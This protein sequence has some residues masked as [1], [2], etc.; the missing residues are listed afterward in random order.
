MPI[1]NWSLPAR[2][3][4]VVAGV[5][6]MM[7]AVYGAGVG[8]V[9]W[10]D[11]LDKRL[12]AAINPDAYLPITDQLFRA[13]SD[14][15]NFL[16]STAALSLLA[17]IGLRRW[18][19]VPRVW[20]A[21]LLALEGVI[22]AGAAAAGWIMPNSVYAGANALFVG[23]LLAVFGGTAYA[24]HRS[25]DAALGRM[26][27]VIGLM[28]ITV[29]LANLV[30]TNVIKGA[31]ARP[32]PLNDVHRPWNEQVRIIPDEVVRGRSSFPSGHTSGAFAL[33]TP[34]FWWL[35]DP[36]ARA[37]VVGWGAMQ[38]LSRVYTAAHFP[39]CVVFGALLAFG[40]GTLVFF[41]LGGRRLRGPAAAG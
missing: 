14:Y 7:A 17:G 31:V 21:R 20:L 24:A 8:L 25:D 18:A 1:E 41:L 26:A 22:L 34:I 35:R 29:V 37:G 30:A 39:S 28:L 15:T 13:T 12:L 40:T 16:I 36:R 23:A 32:R 10:L 5:L 11:P 9:P 19:G 6:A 33:L 4:L 27:R 3:G 38:A 2:L